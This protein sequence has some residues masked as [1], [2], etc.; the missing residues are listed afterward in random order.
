MTSPSPAIFVE[1]R[2]RD[3]AEDHFIG[4]AENVGQHIQATAV[5]HAD[6]H[7]IHAEFSALFD[8]GVH[9]WNQ[10]IAAFIA[11][12]LDRGVFDLQEQLKIFRSDQALHDLLARSRS[13]AGLLSEGSICSSSHA[14]CS[15]SR[16]SM[17]STAKV[18]Q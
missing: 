8:Q 6:R 2:P 10:G 15:E 12:T 7:F 3:F 5:G 16:M 9:Q 1:G 14:R 17:N 13:S 11:E 4:L 18:P